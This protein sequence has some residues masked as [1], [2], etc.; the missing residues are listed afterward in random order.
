MDALANALGPVSLRNTRKLSLVSSH[1]PWPHNLFMIRGY[2]V[3]V[4]ERLEQQILQQGL[5]H[6]F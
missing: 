5:L 6:Y 1:S 3:S 2:S 4:S